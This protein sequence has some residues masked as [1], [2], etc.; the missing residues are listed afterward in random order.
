MFFLSLGGSN[1]DFRKNLTE[2]CPTG[3][4]LD[5]RV[6]SKTGLSVRTVK[7]SH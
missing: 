7:K 6:R 2:G 3:H 5:A 4:V 1:R